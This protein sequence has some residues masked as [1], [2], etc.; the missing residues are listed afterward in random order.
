MRIKGIVTFALLFFGAVMWFWP[1]E[2]VEALPLVVVYKD[3]LCGCC[4]NWVN[5]ME[6]FGFPIQ[7]IE[8]PNHFNVPRSL[9]SC[10]TSSIGNYVFEG[11]VP[12]DYIMTFLDKKPTGIRGLAVPGMEPDTPGMEQ[13]HRRGAKSDPKFTIFSFTDG[14]LS[15]VYAVTYRRQ[16]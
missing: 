6:R 1:T 15:D 3:P 13:G 2:P 16:M 11:H 9:L 7:V 10:H 14:G 5:Y 12:A 4:Q 8:T